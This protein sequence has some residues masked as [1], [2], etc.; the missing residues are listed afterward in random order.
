VYAGGDDGLGRH[1]M[2]G[3]TYRGYTCH[4]GDT[5]FYVDRASGWGWMRVEGKIVHTFALGTVLSRQGA[6][7]SWKFVCRKVPR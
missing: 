5:Y 2:S 3:H 6:T 4:P 1:V 7:D